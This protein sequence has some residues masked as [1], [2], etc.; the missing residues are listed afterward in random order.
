MS[1]GAPGQPQAIPTNAFPQKLYRD[2]GSAVSPSTPE[3]PVPS[4]EFPQFK[5][6]LSTTIPIAK[7]LNPV[8]RA[9]Q[10]SN[11]PRTRSSVLAV[12]RLP[13]SLPIADATSSGLERLGSRPG[14]ICGSYPY[15]NGFKRNNDTCSH[16]EKECKTCRKKLGLKSDLE[17]HE[18]VCECPAH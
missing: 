7:L 2:Q 16:S 3:A 9:R 15:D 8:P 11:D 10:P 14:D 1:Y 18:C 12:P 13:E 4:R 5:K 6:A 17:Y